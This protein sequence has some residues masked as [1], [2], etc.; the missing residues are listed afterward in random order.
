MRYW[1]GDGRGAVDCTLQAIGD[2]GIVLD[3]G[4]KIRFLPWGAVLHIEQD[5][6]GPEQ[7]PGESGSRRARTT[8]IPRR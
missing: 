3:V 7:E 4:D 8:M 2:K 6:S 5:K 1:Y